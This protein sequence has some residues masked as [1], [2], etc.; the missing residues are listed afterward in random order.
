MI[1]AIIQ[2]VIIMENNE[3][4]IRKNKNVNIICGVCLIVTIPV[5]VLL[6]LKLN[7]RNNTDKI[8][9]YVVFITLWLAFFIAWLGYVLWKI[10]FNEEELKVRHF[11]FTNAYKR[12][13]VIAIEEPRERNGGYRN[14]FKKLVAIHNVIRRKDNNRLI[15]EIHDHYMNSEYFKRL[16]TKSKK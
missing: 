2:R 7:Y 6:L 15:A 5:I 10:S 9:A 14:G 8:I 4:V 1:F 13:N 11:F 12:E 16:L 3:Y